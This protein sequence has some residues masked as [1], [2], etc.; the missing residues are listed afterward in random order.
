M[1]AA[2]CSL[3][4]AHFI[5]FGTWKPRNFSEAIVSYSD[6]PGSSSKLS[7]GQGQRISVPDGWKWTDADS[8]YGDDYRS[9]PKQDGDAPLGILTYLEGIKFV[10]GGLNMLFRPNNVVAG[11]N[12]AKFPNPISP[13]PPQPANNNVLMINLFQE[14]LTFSTAIAQGISNRGFKCQGDIC[15]NAIM[16]V[17]TVNDVTN[18]TTG[19]PESPCPS[20]IHAENGMFVHVPA[21]D[22]DPVVGATINRLGRFHALDRDGT[23]LKAGTAVTVPF[24]GITY[25]LTP[26]KDI[27][28]PAGG[29]SIPVQVTELQYF[30]MVVL[31]FGIL[32]WPHPTVST[33]KPDAWSVDQGDAAWNGFESSQMIAQ[34]RACAS[35]L[36]TKLDVSKLR[37][38][39][40]WLDSFRSRQKPGQLVCSYDW[41]VRVGETGKPL[42]GLYVPGNAPTYRGGHITLPRQLEPDPYLRIR[43]QGYPE[44]GQI[45]RVPF[46]AIFNAAK[47]MNPTFRFNDVDVVTTI[48]V[49]RPSSFTIL[50][51]RG[52][53]TSMAAPGPGS[54]RTVTVSK[55][56][57][58]IAQ[59]KTRV[60]KY[61]ENHYRALKIQLGD[62]KCVVLFETDARLGSSDPSESN[63]SPPPT[64]WSLNS[65]VPIIRMGSPAPQSKIAQLKCQYPRRYGGIPRER[66]Q[67]RTGTE[68]QDKASEWLSDFGG[69]GTDEP[70]E[71]TN[72]W[73]YLFFTQTPHLITGFRGQD[74]VLQSIRRSDTREAVRLKASHH[75]PDLCKLVELLHQLRDVTS[76]RGRPCVAHFERTIDS[77]ALVVRRCREL[78]WHPLARSIVDEFWDQPVPE[79]AKKQKHFNKP[80]SR[81]KIPPS[82][83]G[84]DET[85]TP[86]NDAENN[87][88]ETRRR[89]SRQEARERR[90]AARAERAR[91]DV[92]VESPRR[93]ISDAGSP[94]ESTSLQSHL[95]I[96]RPHFP[97]DQ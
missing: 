89:L 66:L 97:S 30:Q 39:R 93:K 48:G 18:T 55:R 28:V 76:K 34:V 24:E 16:Y 45:T 94:G 29:Q 63:E 12:T 59:K 85:Q 11:A 21:T 71:T 7:S 19:L 41:V 35:N 81:S 74:G 1:R 49:L 43:P 87:H 33:L 73:P 77:G 82:S 68:W 92:D 14:T 56:K 15:L 88:G 23:T 36:F 38:R 75:A 5:Q 67:S 86:S 91:V 54:R 53:V 80:P 6:A 83:L 90:R 4:A 37:P 10:G 61:E 27:V 13:T 96:I 3:P 42:V 72:L 52:A 32:S 25:T 62:L 22:N 78:D 95:A 69:H 65:Y 50:L 57:S 26:P 51:P 47:V 8:R 70:N 60:R 44:A 64:G 20:P 2:A 46:E 17:Q 31:Q 58:L 79:V 9:G 84:S 40:D